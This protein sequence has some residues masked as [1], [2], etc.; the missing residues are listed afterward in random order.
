MI[1]GN[2]KTI[3]EV[4]PVT[5]HAIE[6]LAKGLNQQL[7]AGT[8]IEMPSFALDLLTM[9][10]L[11]KTLLAYIDVAK[12]LCATD[13]NEHPDELDDL[14]TLQEKAQALL[15]VQP[16]PKVSKPSTTLFTP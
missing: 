13:L 14:L 16:P 2:P 1:I 7:A 4:N 12:A 10:Q 5:V 15:D 11:T 6:E 3:D 9:S 8:P